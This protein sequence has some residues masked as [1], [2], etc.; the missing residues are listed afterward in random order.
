MNRK[1]LLTVLTLAVV[2]LATPVLGAPNDHAW[3]TVPAEETSLVPGDLTYDQLTTYCLSWGLSENPYPAPLVA[4]ITVVPPIVYI[5]NSTNYHVLTFRI[6]DDNYQVVACQVS[7]GT[8]NIVTGVATLSVQ[9][10]W[11]FGDWGKTNA[12][13]NQGFVGTADVKQYNVNLPTNYSLIQFNLQGFGRF[14]HQ[15]LTLT[16]DTRIS[17]FESGY[18]TVLGNRDKN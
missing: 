10:T 18:C 4:N 13:M 2:L 16:K 3:H 5:N 6:G 11:Y 7:N 14:N 8:V 17:P 1:I 9:V 12:R 15:S